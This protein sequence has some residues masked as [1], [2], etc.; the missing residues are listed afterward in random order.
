VGRRED[1]E[2]AEQMGMEGDKD[3][4][5]AYARLIRMEFMDILRTEYN[6][7]HGPYKGIVEAALTH[8][9]QRID[10]DANL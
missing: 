10:P 8:C 3:K 4:I 1:L 2:L 9:L 5:A 7:W 6:T